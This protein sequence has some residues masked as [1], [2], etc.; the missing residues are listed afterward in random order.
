MQKPKSS[1]SPRAQQAASVSLPPSKADQVRFRV[2]GVDGCTFQCHPTDVRPVLK[3]QVPLF[4][5]LSL[6]AQHP[7]SAASSTQLGGE[8][9]QVSWSL[10][11]R[12][13]RARLHVWGIHGNARRRW[14]PLLAAQLPRSARGAPAPPARGGATEFAHVV[15]RAPVSAPAEAIGVVR[16][17]S[18]LGGGQPLGTGV[19]PCRKAGATLSACEE[20]YIEIRDP[21]IDTDARSSRAPCSAAPPQGS[22][23]HLFPTRGASPVAWGSPVGCEVWR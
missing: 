18:A 17:W 7:T 20:R 16:A 12:Q 14:P 8:G 13:H 10:D 5:L 4:E 3:S 15:W 6:S 2:R 21:A 11:I 1:P 19:G 9:A 22:L 23:R